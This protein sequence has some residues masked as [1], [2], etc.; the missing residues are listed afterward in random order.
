[1][2]I[3]ALSGAASGRPYSSDT[4]ATGTFLRFHPSGRFEN[5]ALLVSH[6]HY[7]SLDRDADLIIKYKAVRADIGTA[8]RRKAGALSLRLRAVICVELH[9][10][11]SSVVA[12]RQGRHK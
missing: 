6:H 3:G 9:L 2:T 5:L 4:L 10:S 1:M 8:A 12:N 11:I 7:H